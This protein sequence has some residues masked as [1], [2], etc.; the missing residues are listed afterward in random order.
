MPARTALKPKRLADAADPLRA[1][2][3]AFGCLRRTGAA[4]PAD[5]RPRAEREPSPTAADIANEICHAL[6]ADFEDFGLID[7]C[8]S[9]TKIWAAPVGALRSRR[10]SAYGP[11]KHE[12]SQSSLPSVGDQVPIPTPEQ[13][14]ATV[15]GEIW[16]RRVRIG[17]SPFAADVTIKLDPPRFFG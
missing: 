12:L 11:V 15:G 9:P 8:F 10:D 16:E 2:R 4:V 17:A 13:I 14:D 7:P 5:A 3:R 6:R 1:W